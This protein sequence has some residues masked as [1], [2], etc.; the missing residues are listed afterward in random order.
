[1]DK[2][3][4]NLLVIDENFGEVEKH[5][6]TEEGRSAL[7]RIISDFNKAR[8]L[9]FVSSGLLRQF[10][11]EISAE[12]ATESDEF[13]W[14]YEHNSKLEIKEKILRKYFLNSAFESKDI[15]WINTRTQD[16]ELKTE[17]SGALKKLVW[18]E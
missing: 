8:W 14:S 12:L 17:T 9:E 4:Y 3:I 6:I 1:M 15:V 13:R 10:A 18:S 16:Q 11:I 2:T 5:L 7:I